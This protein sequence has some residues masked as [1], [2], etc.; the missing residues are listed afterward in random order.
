MDEPEE[1]DELAATSKGSAAVQGASVRGTSVA[2][3]DTLTPA[4][5]QVLDLL[6][7]PPDERPR[8]DADL[9][10]RLLLDLEDGLAGVARRLPADTTL[11]VSKH[12]L[13]QV[14]GCEAKFVAEHETPFAWS[15]PLARGT[16]THKAIELL[17]S[18]PGHPV[19]LD[20]VDEAIA[21]LANDAS[22]LGD[23]LRT[24]GDA[25]RAALRGEVNALVVSFLE[26]FPPLKARWTPVTESR[27]RIELFDGRIV[28]QGRV[29]LALGQPA[30]QVAGK[31][32]IDLKTGG[33]A[34]HHRDDLRFYALL[35]TLRVGTP[36]RLLA[37]YYLDGGRPSPEPVTEALLDTA[38]QRTID[39]ATRMSALLHEGVEPVLRPGPACRWCPLADTC[40]PG[41]AWLGGSDDLDAFSG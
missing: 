16:V 41:S 36:P 5:R 10:Q 13:T 38:T 22:H 29:D 33:F 32:L 14:H 20:V 31:V 39:G 12:P 40:E 15:A 23:W 37:S 9:R 4:Q 26:C 19:P 3:H 2:R 6:G 18:W 25:E 8:F 34:P 30:G 11:W 28:L 24:C 21:R 17:V 35:E 27:V 1:E 7:C